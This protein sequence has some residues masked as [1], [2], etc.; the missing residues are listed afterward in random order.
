MH[1]TFII[2]SIFNVPLHPKTAFPDPL[3][4]RNLENT[5]EAQRRLGNITIHPVM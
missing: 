3:K 1:K 4:T 5:L 2:W